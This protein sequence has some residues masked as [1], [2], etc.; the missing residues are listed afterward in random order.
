MTAP[1]ARSTLAGS[2][3]HA[4]AKA[5][6]LQLVDFLYDRL[7]GGAGA[8]NSSEQDVSCAYLG[9]V[10]TTQLYGQR[11]RLINGG[12]QINQRAVTSA[13]DDAYCLDRWYVLTETGNVSMVQQ[14]DQENGTPF[15]IRLT[16]PDATAKQLGLAQIVESANCRDLRGKT[17][18]LSARIR[19]SAAVQINYAVLEWT[20]SADAVT[21][22]VISAWSGA[23]TYV[24]NIIERA[25]GTIT[26]GVAAWTDVPALNAAISASTNNL[27]VLFWSD[28]DLAQS[29]TLDIARVQLEPGAYA[30]PF[31]FQT[32][33]VALQKCQRYFWKTYSQGMAPATISN[34]GVFVIG[35]AA[36]TQ[37]N[38]QVGMLQFPIEMRAV[39]TIGL[40]NPL[41]GTAGTWADGA[42]NA[43]AVAAANAS[44]RQVSV[45]N[46]ATVIVG[47]T[48]YGHATFAAEL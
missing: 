28:T 22:D 35:R 23:P 26:P 15:N 13:A 8:A 18:T 47:N 41:L 6:Y 17:A 1:P 21:S 11:N 39:P 43:I 40:Y 44:T 46:N 24:A 38:A 10:R 4:S 48:L 30:T 19:C 3:D 45:T 29:V 32:I 36:S 37:I 31:E 5:W 34:E 14:T 2:L 42:S 7:G 33:G 20:G 16:Q 9:A 27:I 12:F 25:K